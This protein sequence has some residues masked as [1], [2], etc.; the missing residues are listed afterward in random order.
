MAIELPGVMGMG[1]HKGLGSE[2]VYLRWRGKVS[3]PFRMQEVG[4]LL[5][6]NRI[7][8][9]HE[10]SNDRR[11]WLPLWRAGIEIEVS[12]SKGCSPITA[13]WHV[14]AEG[15]LSSFREKRE[16]TQDVDLDVTGLPDNLYCPDADKARDPD[17]C[18]LAP[19]VAISLL[20]IG[21][22]PL[23][24]SF[25]G[26]VLA[27]PFAQCAWLF[28]GYFCA[29]W[30]WLLRSLPAQRRGLW[31]HGLLYSVFTAVIGI[32]MLF[33]WMQI[34]TVRLLYSGA[35]SQSTLFQFSGFVLGVGAFEELC[36]AIPLILFGMR[37]RVLRRPTDGIFLGM[38]SGLGFAVNEGVKYTVNFWQGA[39]VL[40][41]NA[42]ASCADDAAIGN[43]AIDSSVLESRLTGL[44]PGLF[45][46]YGR[47]VV[48]QVVRF[49][50]LPLLHAAWAGLVGYSLAKASITGSYPVL[51]SGFVLAATLHGCYDFFL[52]DYPVC[53]ILIA[54]L[55][56][57]IPLFLLATQSTLDSEEIAY[58]R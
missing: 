53:S 32:L 47:L 1:V 24:I 15:A 3:G 42:L 8:R 20:A 48:A 22:G 56:M 9:Y 33:T 2:D 23:V 57:A 51:M 46:E 49:M 29:L 4:R 39:T 14:A 38:Y 44:L 17:L 5:R 6:A 26:G 27:L 55:S 52:A 16:R 50:T 37:T 36:K 10:I 58:V 35:E 7:N 28:S 13:P 34:P 21:L 12:S 43:G 11:R 18:L 54:A 41:A 30:A 45:E 19:R 25:V 31:R 40:A